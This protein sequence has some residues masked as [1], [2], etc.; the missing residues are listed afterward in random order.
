MVADPQPLLN[1]IYIITSF[2]LQICHSQLCGVKETETLL[3][4]IYQ[5][6][7]CRM[8]AQKTRRRYTK[9]FKTDEVR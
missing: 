1:Q 6:A 4:T 5:K 9:E 3:R 8:N 2:L 7:R